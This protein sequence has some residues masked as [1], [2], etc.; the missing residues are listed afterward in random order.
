MAAPGDL[1]SV[2]A[3][4]GNR[5]RSSMLDLLLDGDAHPASE[6]ANQ[7]RVAPSTASGHLRALVEGGLAT[8]HRSGR[9]RRYRISDVRVA[10]A[11]EA[12]GAIAGPAPISSLRGSTVGSQ[13]A[14]GRT[15]YD[16]LAGRLGV[17]VTEALITRGAL[18]IRDGVHTL[19]E[20]GEAFLVSLGTDVEAARK[21]RRPFILACPD[22]TERRP[23]LSGAAGKAL[24]D[25]FFE[26]RWVRRR[27]GTRAVSVT[28]EGVVALRE[29]FGMEFVR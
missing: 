11:L 8:V 27:S 28:G 17:S 23:H 29:H 7:A 12:L 22:W 6:L 5:A 25:L 16:H 1:A 18:R 19:T 14:L 21:S 13:L 26:S 2:G 24:R 10:G 4:I 9:E 15:C 3:L 20:A